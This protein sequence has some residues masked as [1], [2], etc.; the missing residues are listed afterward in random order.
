[1][2]RIYRTLWSIA[3]QSWQAVPETAKSAGKKSKSSASGVVASFALSWILTSTANAQAPP[4]INQLPTG[5]TVVRGT[6]TIN[7]TA[8]A[9]AAAMTVNQT[10]QR[11]VVNWNTF[12]IG[13]NA[14]VNFVQ[15]NAQAI[16]LNRVSDSNPSQIFGRMTANGQVVLTNANGIYFAPG[17]SVDV[18]AITATTHSI[19]DDNFMSGK[20]VF[21]RNGATGKII[22]EGNITAAL[23]GYVA[24]LAP[25]VQNTGVVVARAG[26]VA[27]AAGETITLNIDGAGSLAGIN[28]TPSAI[29]TLI[30]NKQA[31][32]APDGQIIL[33]A[34]ALNKLQAGVIKNSGS[35]EA[36]SLVSKG[37]KIVL[38]ADDITLTATSKLEAKGAT[39]GGTVLVGGDWQGSGDLRQATKVTMEAGATIDASATDKGDGGKVVLWSDVHSADSVTTV[40]GTIH[41][42]GRGNGTRGGQIETSGAH[43]H[44]ADTASIRMGGDGVTG[45]KW[46]LDPKDFKIGGASSD[47]SG[48]TLSGQISAGSTVEVL[49][50]SGAGGTNGD[51][52]IYDNLNWNNTGVLKLSAARGIGGTGN[53][54]MMTGG[55]TVIF[56]LAGNY[57]VGYQ[58]VIS[59][60]GSFTKEGAGTITLSGTNTYS[61]TTT[62]SGGRLNVGFG[63]GSTGTLGTG[64]IIT[65]ADLSFSRNGTYSLSSLASYAGAITGTGNISIS[66]NTNS[67]TVDRD[68]T[69]S[70]PSSRIYIETNASYNPWVPGGYS[71][72]YDVTL[73]N[74]ITTSNTGT[75]TIFSGSPSTVSTSTLMSKMVGATGALKYKT[76]NTGGSYLIPA[77]EV[78]GTRNFF[79][80]ARVDL[81]ASGTVTAN[82]VYDG[83]IS[84]NNAT[85]TGGTV[86][87]AIDDDAMVAVATGG[88]YA[89]TTAG[90][91]LVA[92]SATTDVTSASGSGW[93]VTGHTCTCS[94]TYT[95][96]ITA[97][98]LTVTGTSVADK[99]YNGTNAASLSGGT[100]VGVINGD[101]V[102][103]TQSGTFSQTGVGNGIS[104][105]ATDT[106]SGTSARN[107]SLVQPTGLT[108]KILAKPLTI[109]G[110]T[111][112]NKPYDG[113]DVA[114]LS[115]STLVGVITGDTVTL[116]QA[117]TFAQTG[118]GTGIS[119]T[120]NISLGGISAGNYSLT[121][122]T[123]LR[124]DITAKPLTITPTL[125]QS[126]YYGDADATLTYTTSG[127]VGNDTLSGAL[128]RAAGESVGS[129]A[130]SIAGMSATNYALT[131][132]AGADQFAI[133]Q[134][135][136]TITPASLRK[137]Y[138]NADPTFTAS[139]TSGSLASVTVSDSLADVIAGL[140]RTSGE[141]AGSYDVVL[142]RGPKASSY[143]ITFAT[144]NQAFTIDP[145]TSTST[146][147]SPSP[148]SGS[149][150]NVVTKPY[151]PAIPILMATAGATS[152]PAQALSQLNTDQLSALRSNAA[153]APL[154]QMSQRTATPN[155]PVVIV[156]PQP[157]AESA[158]RTGV[159]PVTV[160]QSTN[161][162]P[163]TSGVAFEQTEDAVSLK[164]TTAPAVVVQA[165]KLA[166][167]DK[168]TSFTVSLPT[169]DVVVYEGGLVNN[170]LVIVATSTHAKR[171][172][173]NDLKLVLSTAI[174]SLGKDNRVMLDKLKS[175]LLDL[176]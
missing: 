4:A 33:S 74:T 40:A 150:T 8:T 133:N 22:N 55:G 82:K 78:L 3:T 86:T 123:G 84:T 172:A 23:A 110:T 107:Y 31:V 142:T 57:A 170:R 89:N 109:N 125:N 124:A 155:E 147:P 58:G 93:V 95:G 138:G 62:V 128:A 59:G 119:V 166:V 132:A 100:L 99:T 91:V 126:K 96:T 81:S 61:G 175:V 68:I 73:N 52:F 97:K 148:S 159:L 25:E 98:P 21:E 7:Q 27:M 111:A 169:G 101:T 120:A 130:Y 152:I 66:S 129:Y 116:N 32:Q 24:L 158:P 168:L 117:G 44:V 92:N 104:V 135:P 43:L 19:T 122:P 45:G 94:F 17:S 164:I 1:M 115:G 54:D 118:L 60:T 37:G 70:G 14:S 34:V 102:T 141:S 173:R 114:S 87:G 108:A 139:I 171:V 83:T 156:P 48:T 146:S 10:S 65:N 174:N 69:L 39:G 112:A 176:R 67:V 167:S 134:R 103:L 76:Y 56:N 46:L 71:A 113:T 88:N 162:K 12:N 35:L 106:L 15:P 72:A 79:Y 77:N 29:A 42:E 9:Q 80:R 160:L 13:S 145:S 64:P 154:V 157:T 161:A 127:M 163:A 136:I 30:E 41:A 149:S 121:Q 137:T 140:S 49:S 50:S 11:A 85:F 18:G 2:N 6:A 28:T 47:I 105:T 153:P 16:T 131:L 143:L 53:I 165:P 36:N 5:G 151:V 51:I 38:E 26:T 75:I 90:S 144:N 20:Y 63:S